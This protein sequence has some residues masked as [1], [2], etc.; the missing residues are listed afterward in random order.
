MPPAPSP[1]M[2]PAVPTA[3]AP[4]PATP[5]AAPPPHATPTRD[6]LPCPECSIEL[7]LAEGELHARISLLLL[8]S[9]DAIDLDVSSRDSSQQQ[10]LLLSVPGVYSDL[11]VPLDHA[12]D[13]D[14]VTAKFDKGKRE[15]GL[16]MRIAR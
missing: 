5:S 1:A 12:V 10:L 7:R 9:A 6:V 16:T 3:A 8:D 13:E 15:L 4:S 11:K 14:A 2:P